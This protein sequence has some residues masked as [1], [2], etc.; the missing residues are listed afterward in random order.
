MTILKDDGPL[1]LRSIAEGLKP[2]KQGS[3]D[4]LRLASFI[5]EKVS[6]R[7]YYSRFVTLPDIQLQEKL[8]L[9]PS[10]ATEAKRLL[11]GLDV[12]RFHKK[13]RRSDGSW[14]MLWE[15]MT[16]KVEVVMPTYDDSFVQR[17]VELHDEELELEE[18]EDDLDLE[19]FQQELD[20]EFKRSNYAAMMR[21]LRARE[22]TIKLEEARIAELKEAM[23]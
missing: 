22:E 13:V 5:N 19:E 15:M 18:V 10:R 14:L 3:K 11:K 17:E 12:L 16:V 1:D 21:E 8:E 4:A 2:G 20:R 7:D 9:T 6:K 23:K